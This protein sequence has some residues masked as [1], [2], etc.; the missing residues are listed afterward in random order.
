MVVRLSSLRTGR[1]Y[2]QEIHLVLISVGGW[3][4]LRII[5][6]PEGVCH[7]KIS[8]TPSGIEPATCQFVAWCTDLI[9]WFFI[10][11]KFNGKTCTTGWCYLTL[12]YCSRDW[13]LRQ[14]LLNR[15]S[16]QMFACSL[17]WH[18]HGLVC[19]GTGRAQWH[20]M[21][22]NKAFPISSSTNESWESS[23]SLTWQV[24]KH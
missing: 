13:F 20:L 14:R 18:S 10:H 2:H 19:F 5:V 6:R 22:T 23:R 1:L 21:S 24:N 15:Y 16:C 8:V 11:H 4:D 7:W 17:W 12:S 3:V 9:Y